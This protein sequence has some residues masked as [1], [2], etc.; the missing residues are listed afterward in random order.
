MTTN[1]KKKL[2]VL[3]GGV[4][5]MMAAWR[6]TCQPNWK[7]IYES[8]TVYQM[9]WRLG[10]KCASGRRE[11]YER[12]EEHGLH[13][14]LGFYDNSFDVMQNA[15]PMLGRPP[16]SPLATWS[17]AFKKHSYV[18]F[19]QSFNGK[20]YPWSFDFPENSLVPGKGATTPT[21]WEYI[22][23]LIDF[24]I[25]HF[26]NTGLRL[27]V[28]RET[29]SEEHQSAISRL[30]HFVESRLQSFEFGAETLAENIL[31]IVESYVSDF[32][33]GVRDA[34]EADHQTILWLL[35]ELLG[36][37]RRQHLG[38]L[39]INLDVYRFVVVMDLAITMVVG[40]LCDRV[41][42][43]PHKLDAL[44]GE[45]FREW[46]ARHGALKETL[47]C[48]LLR[49]F[50]DLVFGYHDGKTDS[51][52]F[53]AGTSIRCLFRIL[54]SYKGAIFWKMQA[55]MGD[56][57]FTP[58]FVALKKRGVSFK[59]FHQVQNLA[60]SGDKTSIE[61]I[62]IGKQ[63]TLKVGDEYDPFVKVKDL[64]CWPAVPNYN[65]LVEGEELKKL[66]V[67][68]ESFY[69]T[70]K[71][72]EEITLQR[73]K[74]FDD[75]VF[76]ISLGSVP[77][78]CK[79]LLAADAKWQTMVDKV[80]TT[81]TMA[82]QAWIN[83]DLNEL[84]W[85][86]KSAIMD[87]YVE[88]MDTWADMS[89]L[90]AREAYPE[91]ANIKNI[92][93]FCG[94]MEG[95]IPPQSEID[96]PGNALKIVA[97]IS[98]SWLEDHSK[99]W[100]LRFNQECV[101]DIFHRANID[102]SERYVLSTKGSTPYRLMGYQSGFSNLYVAGDWTLNG[103]NAGCVEAATISGKIVGNVLSGNSPLKDVWGYGDFDGDIKGTVLG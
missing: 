68:L 41:L 6:L 56:T 45:D 53:A 18:V 80:E 70:W 48:D 94:P 97:N 73:E 91:S 12:I 82:F 76:G 46:L 19:A 40:L 20:W 47:S 63:A 2:V 50:Y 16:G 3:G 86:D 81:R 27:H 39:S 21:V 102:P 17:D 103:L 79:E 49:G 58:L 101:V 33:E 37:I 15:Y 9:G 13:I 93:Y 57:V 62:S 61:R 92:S 36:A 96:T 1:Q 78:L 14:W 10:G 55:G 90:I 7:D 38:E 60:L 54:F 44:D 74:D 98:R 24:L 66:N 4:G 72:V 25:K 22:L 83:K 64:D 67:D 31:L 77:Y 89:Q 32:A 8:V 29:E 65:Q 75:I 35:Q 85:N 95:G 52:S 71:G 59:F 5:S 88:P 51:P 69:T 28:E 42:F 26:R 84:G 87:A 99:T 11:P 23:S 30:A 100:W 34:A 43:H